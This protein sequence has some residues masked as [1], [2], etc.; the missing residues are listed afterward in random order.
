VLPHILVNGRV[1]PL[2]IIRYLS[3]KSG[4]IVV[5]RRP[6]PRAKVPVFV[7]ESV[8]PRNSI[9]MFSLL[10]SSTTRTYLEFQDGRRVPVRVLRDF[11][12]PFAVL[13]GDYDFPTL[14]AILD[15]PVHLF[16]YRVIHTDTSYPAVILDTDNMAWYHAVSRILP[17]HILSVYDQL[18]EMRVREWRRRSGSGY[19]SRRARRRNGKR[20]GNYSSILS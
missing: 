8:P 6:V 18:V 13:T 9:M 11:S 5:E 12:D 2:S 10:D 1:F 16:V 3:L 17:S 19:S 15:D 4:R 14:S 20:T 7:V